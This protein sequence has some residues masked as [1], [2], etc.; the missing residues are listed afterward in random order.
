MLK[1][2]TSEKQRGKEVSHLE[3]CEYT[4][5]EPLSEGLLILRPSDQRDIRLRQENNEALKAIQRI[6]MTEEDKVMSLEEVL[7]RV[8]GFYDRFVPYKGTLKK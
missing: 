7:A 5:E 2:Q 6:I 4:L 1:E 8:L 3:S